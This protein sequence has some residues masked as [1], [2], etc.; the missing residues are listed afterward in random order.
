MVNKDDKSIKVSF[1]WETIDFIISWTLNNS[2][3]LNSALK[4]FFNHYI[5]NKNI[6]DK[7]DSV[8]IWGL[9]VHKTDNLSLWYSVWWDNDYLTF[10]GFLKTSE[11]NYWLVSFQ[12]YEF[13]IDEIDED[14][15]MESM[16]KYLISYYDEYDTFTIKD[17]WLVKNSRGNIFVYS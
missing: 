1:Y 16:V 6:D 10:I 9:S 13:N 5:L 2:K 15:T 14:S 8:S 7:K 3:E 4:L 11:N 17:S 12:N